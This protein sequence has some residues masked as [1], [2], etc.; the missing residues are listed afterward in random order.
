MAQMNLS[1]YIVFLFALCFHHYHSVLSRS[2]SP[3]ESSENPQYSTTIFDVAASIQ[4]T[5]DVL[6][7]DPQFSIEH[8]DSFQSQEQEKLTMNQSSSS[9]SMTLHP[10]SSLHKPFHK[11]YEALT[12]SR[13]ERDSARVNSI[14]AK[15]E[16]A[17]NGDDMSKLKPVETTET[18]KTTSLSVQPEDLQSPVT[19]GESQGSGEYFSRVGV[20][21]PAREYYMVLDTGSDV[22][23]LQCSPCFNCYQQSDPI[24]DPSESSTYRPVPC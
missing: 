5:L 10:R 7:F 20:G 19:S 14:A 24:F 6:S 15:L 22:S 17:L 3:S 2:L 12:L 16:L 4:R 23:W 21:R 11:D 18:M 8:T 9:F 13:L 1:V